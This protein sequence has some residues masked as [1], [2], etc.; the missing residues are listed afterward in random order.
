MIGAG[1][2]LRIRLSE[3]VA[4]T[5]LA[6][7]DTGSIDDGGGGQK[8]DLHGWYLSAFVRISF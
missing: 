2:G 6:R 8:S 7:Y 3:T 5:P 4:L 1:S